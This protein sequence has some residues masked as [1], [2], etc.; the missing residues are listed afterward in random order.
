MARR[1]GKEVKEHQ[2]SDLET[3]LNVREVMARLKVSSRESLY[4]LM[5]QGLPVVRLGGQLRFI[6]SEVQKWLLEQQEIAY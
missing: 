4:K 2:L 5:R 3:L 1:Y 6:P